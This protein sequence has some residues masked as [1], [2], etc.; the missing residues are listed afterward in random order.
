MK[1]VHVVR[2]EAGVHAAQLGEAAQQQRRADDEPQRRGDLK[3]DERVARTRSRAPRGVAAG[4]VG[5]RRSPSAARRLE[6]RPHADGDRNRREHR[7]GADENRPVESD[8]LGARQ[9]RRQ[10]RRERGD[11]PARGADSDEAAGGQHRHDFGD[12]L[13]DQASAAGA[14]R[15]AD[16][17]LALAG[18]RARDEQIGEIRAAD[19]QHDA[20]R[21]EQDVQRRANGRHEVLKRWNDRS[22]ESRVLARMLAL[23]L[24]RDDVHLGLRLL[25]RHARFQTRDR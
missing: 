14:E 2:I 23:E 17:E 15:R 11:R 5:N 18:E 3:D 6:R 22:A 7:R 12:R 10:Q 8:V 24:G 1:A 16:R 9:I 19:Q 13:P 4:S 20:D 25:Q 21:G